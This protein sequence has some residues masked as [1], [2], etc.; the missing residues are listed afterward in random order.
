MELKIALVGNPNCGKTTLFN[1]LTGSSQY[2]GN[3]P[4]VTVEKKEG[5]LRGHKDI[6]ITDLPGIYSLSP[7]TL[8][9]VVSRDY[10]VNQRP[11]AIIN[12]ID[13]TNLERNL[14]LTTQV[15]ELGIPVVI[16]L[17]MIDLVK[18]NG[19]KI[20]IKK[21]SKELGCE[22]IETSA[23]KGMGSMEAAEKAI[24][25]AKEK[26]QSV[27]KNSFSPSVEEALQSISSLLDSGIK[28][29]LKRWYAVKLFEQDEK[30]MKS[31]T[32]QQTTVSAI[33]QI[34]EEIEEKLDDDSESIIT[35]ERYD[36]IA[37]VIKM[38]VSKNKKAL[39]N[40]DRIDQIVTNRWLALPIFVVIMWGIYYIAITVGT[41]GTDWIND[42]L[43]GE[44]LTNN[45]TNW[46]ESVSLASWLQG[47]IT[48]GILGGVGTVLGFLPQIFLLFFFIAILE[49]CG[50][51]ARI[52]F[53]MDRIFRRFGLSGKSFIP[54]L[55]ATGCGVPG[56]MASRTIE[57]ERDRK[58]T[59]MMTT[60]IPCS[61]K[62]PIIA[63]FAGALFPGTS[64]IAPS[65]YF[66]GIA[67]VI[68]CGILLKGTKMFSGEVAAF[69]MELPQYHIPS[70][71]G[72]LIHMWDRSKAFIKKA[73]TIILVACSAIWFLQNFNWSLQEVAAG[74]S[75][76]ADMGRVFAV[77]F[78]PLGFGNWQAAV[79]TITGL[80][81][82]ENVVA[83]YGILFN[84]ADATET[85]GQ[86]LAQ[87]SGIFTGPS[88]YA[89]VI[90][91]MLC[92]PCFAAIGAI[93][94]EMG[95]KKWTAITLAFQ[96]ITAYLVAL[97]I[98]QVGSAIFE[99]GSV[100]N[101]II[102]I[103]I[104]AAVVAFIKIVSRNPKDK[105]EN[106]KLSYGK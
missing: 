50:Y 86:L 66:M 94:R 45:I 99:G 78:A 21:L 2:V 49:D 62:L 56:I 7:Y 105:Y 64:F 79:A 27:L 33:K 39:T 34:V 80:V 13:G 104:V 14:Y 83:T 41:K 68:I 16:A 38:A 23:L 67:M 5:K 6:I 51:M 48:T 24:S 93:H 44:I 98:Y 101:A 47:L 92:P 36:Y 15:L 70:I 26:K 61:A 1:D 19:D 87:L 72:V 12:L 91:N 31:L 81:A 4:G 97:V 54:M 30:V 103:V 95:S 65:V 22:V 32:L 75:I 102:A 43:F 55:V 59:I 82:K 71:K 10:L 90:F 85:N 37:K 8:E 17:N 88:A 106:P 46:M 20:D 74:D 9:E 52:A 96:T 58:L 73:G 57:N 53:I 42:V 60:F 18:K 25:L 77:L 63:L 11:D 28:E 100:I 89:L 3:W 40:S 29:E 35:S 76:L 84:I 69:V